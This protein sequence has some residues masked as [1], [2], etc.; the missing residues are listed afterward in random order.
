MGRH[1]ARP[2]CPFCGWEYTDL[3]ELGYRARPRRPCYRVK[4]CRCRAFG[5]EGES[6]GE[7]ISLWNKREPVV[8]GLPVPLDFERA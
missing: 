7:A 2:G 6:K 1:S 8:V 5:P 4:C 3:E